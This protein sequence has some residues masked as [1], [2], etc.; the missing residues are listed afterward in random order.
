MPIEYRQDYF[1]GTDIIDIQI[2]I[3]AGGHRDRE[4]HRESNV[5]FVLLILQ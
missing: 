3:Q 2:G 4:V 1:A 5:L